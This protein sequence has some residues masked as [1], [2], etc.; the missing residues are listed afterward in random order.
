MHQR[1]KVGLASL[2]STLRRLPIV[3]TFRATRYEIR[4][5]PVT[6]ESRAEYNSWHRVV[7][8]QP[9]PPRLGE[10][11]DPAETPVAMPKEADCRPSG[12][13]PL[14]KLALTLSSNFVIRSAMS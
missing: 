6:L 1:K 14:D 8:F 10:A 5:P 3:K 4:T 9:P 11:D 13:Y 12:H 7:L 2:D